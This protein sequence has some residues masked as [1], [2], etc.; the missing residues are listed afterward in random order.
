MGKVKAMLLEQEEYD[1]YEPTREEYL[2]MMDECYRDLDP[3]A[4][5]IIWCQCD[6]EVGDNPKC[7]RHGREK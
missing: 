3:T 7:P 4:Q 2:E 1:T 6:E 5:I